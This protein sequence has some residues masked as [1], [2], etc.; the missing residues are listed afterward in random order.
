MTH[1]DTH[2]VVWLYAGQLER[3]P[4]AARQ[5]LQQ[6]LLLVSPMVILELTYLYEIGRTTVPGPAVVDDLKHRIGL[7]VAD[8]PFQDIVL[9]APTMSWTRD[10]FDRLIAAQATV[11]AAPLL[12]AD[13]RILDNVPGA[14]WG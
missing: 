6:G 12:T 7:Q 4:A 9:A 2:V 5:R 14:V 11:E 10:P 13:E 8:T 3:I 1:L